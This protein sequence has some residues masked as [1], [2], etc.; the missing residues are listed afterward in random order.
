[1][2]RSRARAR[3]DEVTAKMRVRQVKQGAP[4]I[5]VRDDGDADSVVLSVRVPR[6]MLKEARV[7]LEHALS[8]RDGAAQVMSAITSLDALLYGRRR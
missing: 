1:V 7:A 6:A 2:T 3:G 8:I 4:K 5:E